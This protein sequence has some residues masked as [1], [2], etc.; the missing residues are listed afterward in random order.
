MYHLSLSIRPAYVA[1]HVPSLS[2]H[3]TSTW[4]LSCT[5]SLCPLDQ[6]M[7]LIM[8]H[9]SLSIRPAHVAYHAPSLS[10]H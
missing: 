7:E 10:V 5:I 6:R 4:S 8:Y 3:K 9:L 2:V 1:Y